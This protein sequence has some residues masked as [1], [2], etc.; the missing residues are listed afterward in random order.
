MNVDDEAARVQGRF[1]PADGE[2]HHWIIDKGGNEDDTTLNLVH[3]GDLIKVGFGLNGDR[4]GPPALMG[5][6]FV[7]YVTQAGWAGT[8]RQFRLQ[9]GTAPHTAVFMFFA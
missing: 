7:A 1:G 9:H 2:H 3:A 6:N 4:G 8:C 5:S